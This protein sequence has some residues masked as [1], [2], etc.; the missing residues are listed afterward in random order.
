MPFTIEERDVNFVLFEQ[1]GIED[2]CGTEK[3]ADFE[4]D[5]FKMILEEAG[6]VSKNLLAPLNEDSDR[7]GCKI[8]DGQVY[9]P[10]GFKEAYEQYRE[11]GWIGMTHNPEFGG[12]GLPNVI[13]V[14][15]SERFLAGCTA[16]SMTPGL[17]NSA[18]HVIE[19]HGTDWMKNTFCENMYTGKWAGTMCLTESGAGSAVGDT[20]TTAKKVEG[21]DLWKITGTKTFIS[22]GDH[23]LTENI[24]HLVLARTPGAPSG[25]KGISLFLIPK[26]KVDEN[27]AVGGSNDVNV[28]NIEHKMGINGSSTC[29]LN[30]GDNNDCEGW[31]IGE[32]FA[33]IKYMFLMMNEARIGVG[34]MGMSLAA[35]SYREALDYARER[36]QGTDIRDMKDA[37]AARVPIIVHPDIK[38][39]LLTMKAYSEGCRALLFECA[40]FGDK[41]ETSG[42][43]KYKGFVELLTP[44]CKAYSTDQGFTT[45]SLGVQVLGG[46]GYCQEYPL[47]QHMRDQRINSIYE[48]TNGIQALDLIGRKVGAK[49]GMLLMNYLMDLA[50]FI[51]GNSDDEL[52]GKYVTSLGGYRDKLAEVTMNFGMMRDDQ[53]YPV[54][55]AT[56]YLKLFGNVVIAALLLKQAKIAAEKLAAKEADATKWAALAESDDEVK[57]YLGKVETAKFFTTQLLPEN[58]GLADSMASGDR[59]VIEVVL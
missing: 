1:L 41:F 53:L 3:F 31:L 24:I 16:F 4:V 38:R 48:G 11:G 8:E 6:K 34:M 33:G 28:T 17:T 12:Q 54:S 52:L 30:F 9:M 32:E 23:D 49:G 36:I 2:L 14:A 13:G 7:I 40:Y 37:D 26:N 20:K 58:I 19:T 56:P 18:A 39:M 35:A 27:G 57:F 45:C 15:C 50:T 44:I 10:P 43:D 5:D 47:E 25:I 29:T 59:S 21:S 42:D 51:D 55:H 46:Y 22:S